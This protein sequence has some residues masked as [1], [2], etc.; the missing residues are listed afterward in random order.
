M[1]NI[2]FITSWGALLTF[3]PPMTVNAVRSLGIE[4]QEWQGYA[5]LDHSAATQLAQKCAMRLPTSAELFELHLWIN[6]QVNHEWPPHNIYRSSTS[7]T[8]GEHYS[9]R[10]KNGKSYSVNDDYYGFVSC[11]FDS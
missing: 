6:Q 1:N 8:D 3:T 10:L 7:I 4:C 2:S 5:D 11:V 9:V